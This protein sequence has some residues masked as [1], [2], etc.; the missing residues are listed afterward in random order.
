[1]SEDYQCG[2][3]SNKLTMDQM[4]T[5]RQILEKGLE[6]NIEKRHLFVDFEAANNSINRKEML[7]ILEEIFLGNLDML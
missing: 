5:V 3:R 6:C 7:E 2:F 4:F 1:M